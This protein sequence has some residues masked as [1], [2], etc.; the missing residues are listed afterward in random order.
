LETLQNRVAG[1]KR[2]EAF[3]YLGE[4][5]REEKI[6]FLQSLDVM[7]LPTV[8]RES[9]G[10]PVL[11]AWANAVGV[12]LPNHGAFPELVEQTGG[13]LLHEPLDPVALA[14]QLRRLLHDR[15]EAAALG[16]RGQSAVRRD[17]TATEM[18]KK[19]RDLYRTV[20]S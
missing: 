4:L 3:E 2:P 11:E 20:V 14:A 10:L 15:S 16:A 8:Y 1:W 17:F 18:A 7:S 13:G 6:A 19:T 9:K 5:T 12:V